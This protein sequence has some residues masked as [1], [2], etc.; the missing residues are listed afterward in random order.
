MTTTTDVPFAGLKGGV[1]IHSDSGVLYTFF[2]WLKRKDKLTASSVVLI[3]DSGMLEIAKE[4]L[5]GVFSFEDAQKAAADYGDGF[6]CATRHEAIEMYDARLRGLNVALA[7]IGGKPAL[8]VYWTC[9]VDPEYSYFRSF[10][11]KGVSGDI[12]GF[13][14]DMSF[15]VRP[16]RSFRRVIWSHPDGCR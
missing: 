8:S 7:A 1:Y 6:R 10:I 9:D 14:R 4:D 13:Y 5:S 2:E 16:G 15:A 11:Y 3:T 12:L